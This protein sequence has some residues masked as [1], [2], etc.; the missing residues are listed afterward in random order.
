MFINC[1]KNNI[2]HF[3]SFLG[4]EVK[5]KNFVYPVLILPNQIPELTNVTIQEWGVSV[6]AAVTLTDMETAL[7]HQ[8]S[9]EPSN[10]YI[11][12]FILTS[13]AFLCDIL[14][15]KKFYLLIFRI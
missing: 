12:F 9:S 14:S 15:L 2:S 1:L 7:N 3:L 6:G 13:S 11:F 8:I 5:F 10:I 4:V